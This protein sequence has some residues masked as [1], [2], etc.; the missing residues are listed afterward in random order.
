MPDRRLIVQ[1]WLWWAVCALGLRMEGV[2]ADL[3]VDA[4][5]LAVERLWE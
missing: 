4:A 5:D 2:E 3:A 1:R